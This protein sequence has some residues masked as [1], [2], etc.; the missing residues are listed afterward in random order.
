MK[1][2][3]DVLENKKVVTEVICNCCGKTIE[4]AESGRHSDYLSV[5]KTWGYLSP[6]DNEI[7]DFDICDSCYERF[8]E[9]FAIPVRE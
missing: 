4:K 2:Y 6:F 3:D 8:I 9:S 1:K 5:E 7:H